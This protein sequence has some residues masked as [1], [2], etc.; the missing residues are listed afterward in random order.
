MKNK[1]KKYYVI[2]FRLLQGIIDD[3]KLISVMNSN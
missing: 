1:K 3:K 2:S